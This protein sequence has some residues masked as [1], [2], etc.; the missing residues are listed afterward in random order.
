MSNLN[1][2]IDL[3]KLPGAK[4]ME[5]QGE[6]ST[7]QCVVLPIDNKVGIVCDGYIG[8]DPTTGLPAEKFFD[9]V[10]LNLVGIQYKEPKYGATHGLKAS[11]STEYMQRMTE[12]QLRAAPWLGNVKPWA[13]PA[14]KPQVDDD[15]LP[16]G[17]ESNW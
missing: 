16:E 4:V 12:E 5:I 10:R 9:H 6:R 11:Y 14:S 3:T 7:R 15:D 2:S 13:Q 17:N 1:L 8:K